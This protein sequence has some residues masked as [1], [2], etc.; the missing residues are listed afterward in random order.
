M[1]FDSLAG[2]LRVSVLELALK[3]RAELTGLVKV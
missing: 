3:R 2:V 1:P